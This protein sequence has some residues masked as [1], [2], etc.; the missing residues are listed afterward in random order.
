MSNR[1]E[2]GTPASVLLADG[3]E[4]PLR[5]PLRVLRELKASHNIDM[6]GSAG[7]GAALND[8][9]ILAVLLAAGMK[10]TDDSITLEWVEDNVDASMLV[11]IAPQL[12]YAATGQWIGD[13]LQKRV[14]GA[15][16]NAPASDGTGNGRHG[17]TSGLSDAMT[18]D[19]QSPT[20][21]N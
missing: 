19:S 2:P 10:T 6:L 1:P 15:S 12:V 16:G 17:S 7:I 5:F 4:H 13:E 8:P 20:S 11:S 18:S 14:N 21:G 9:A 3:R